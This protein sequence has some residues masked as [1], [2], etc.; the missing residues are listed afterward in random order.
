MHKFTCCGSRIVIECRAFGVSKTRAQEGVVRQ[1]Q[2]QAGPRM[3]LA[4][5]LVSEYIV[6]PIGRQ[7][8]Y[9]TFPRRYFHQL[10]DQLN[11]LKEKREMIQHRVD[12]EIRNG[13]EIEAA[14]LVWM[15]KADETLDKAKDLIENSYR[16]K[17]GCS[18]L[19]SS[20]IIIRR[21]LSKRAREMSQY[22]AHIRDEGM[23]DKISYRLPLRVAVDSTFASRRGVISESRSSTLELVKF[24]SGL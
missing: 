3:D 18:G 22:Y 8:R 21:R 6:A 14:V 1:E 11:Q 10:E 2:S 23:L 13:C 7:V 9:L 15:E 5:S 20:N 24:F 17:A 19:S 4:T 16:V 12:D